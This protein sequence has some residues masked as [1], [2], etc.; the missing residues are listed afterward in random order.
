M[1]TTH[2]EAVNMRAFIHS[3]NN[4]I[5]NPPLFG[6][7]YGMPIRHTGF[8]AYVVRLFLT[9]ILT[10]V[11]LG[12]LALS[13]EAPE[14]PFT[15]AFD[16]YP[17]YHYW[18]DG[19]P[20]GLNIDLIN[21]TFSRIGIKPRYTRRPWRRSL[22]DVE[23]GDVSALCA[24]MKTPAREQY[25]HFPS[26]HLSLE[27]NWVISLADNTTP[28]SKLEDLAGLRVGVVSD[29]SYG[30]S[31]DSLNGSTPMRAGMKKHSSNC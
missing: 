6:V 4:A 31:F 5:S 25:A 26:R 2:I 16:D 1:I 11:L 7:L 12:G 30:P 24:G 18:V 20:T 23:N 22:K 19:I 27:T 28:I 3:G 10:V 8:F 14:S 17:P 21:E 13:A 29:Y 9:A 15:I